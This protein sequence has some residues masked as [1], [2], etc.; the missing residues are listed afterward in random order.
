MRINGTCLAWWYLWNGAGN[1]HTFIAVFTHDRRADFMVEIAEGKA[2][3]SGFAKN[4]HITKPGWSFTRSTRRQA[5]ARV[6]KYVQ[7]I[8]HARNTRGFQTQFS[9]FHEYTGLVGDRMMDAWEE[10][11]DF[12][13][14][15]PGMSQTPRPDWWPTRANLR[16]GAWE[17]RPIAQDIRKQVHQE[18]F[19]IDALV[20]FASSP[21]RRKA[22]YNGKLTRRVGRF[23]VYAKDN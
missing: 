6:L 14:H 2:S 12:L 23:T 3:M 21:K 22:K 8:M 5:L 11:H 7:E 4:D 19:N 15:G 17:K 20:T 13:T 9:S 10:I 16:S 18:G 1:A